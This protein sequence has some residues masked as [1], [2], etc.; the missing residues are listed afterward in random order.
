MGA[1]AHRHAG[2]FHRVLEGE[3]DAAR[4]ALIRDT[5]AAVDRAA[6][7][8]LC[9]ARHSGSNRVSS[10]GQALE[11]EGKSVLDHVTRSGLVRV[12]LV[13]LSRSVGRADT[14]NGVVLTLHFS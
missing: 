9:S 4:G 2:D 14:R 6:P 10:W 11:V 7:P 5:L 8:L 12:E 1:G 13:K 3:E